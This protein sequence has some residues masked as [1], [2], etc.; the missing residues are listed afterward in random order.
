MDF[1][2]LDEFVHL[3][4]ADRRPSIRGSPPRTPGVLTMR[5]PCCAITVSLPSMGFSPSAIGGRLDPRS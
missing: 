5:T 4:N 3:R 2:P 1:S